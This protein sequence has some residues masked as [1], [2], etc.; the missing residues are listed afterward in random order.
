[1][2]VFTVSIL[3]IVLVIIFMFIWK[4]KASKKHSEGISAGLL[5]GKLQGG[6]KKPNW[7][8][9][10]DQYKG[11]NHYIAPIDVQNDEI[12]KKMAIIITSMGGKVLTVED[13][14]LHATFTSSLFGFVDDVEL[15]FD[16]SQKLIHLRSA[17]RQGYSDFNAN[18]KRV[19][20][21]K[22]SIK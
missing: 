5:E 3:S 21:L 17:S 1:M 11:S 13:A 12:W 20:K 22:N 19:N 2:I 16:K 9:S 14:Y 18:R 10:E 8:C 15:R 6:P 4:A 7:I